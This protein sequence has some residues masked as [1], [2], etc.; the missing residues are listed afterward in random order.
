MQIIGS[1]CSASF[2]IGS[3]FHDFNLKTLCI[4]WKI[5]FKEPSQFKLQANIIWVKVM[6]NNV[7]DVVR[8]FF[9]ENMAL[10]TKFSRTLCLKFILLMLH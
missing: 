10:P 8:P 4:C 6:A 9:K 1:P 3:D 2:N 5:T 7:Q